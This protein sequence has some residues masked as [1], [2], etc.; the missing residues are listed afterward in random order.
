MRKYEQSP[1]VVVLYPGKTTS[2]LCSVLSIM[3]SLPSM[4]SIVFS[5]PHPPSCAFRAAGEGLLGLG[6]SW[7][8][9]RAWCRP[10]GPRRVTDSCQWW[11]MVVHPW[12]VCFQKQHGDRVQ[13]RG[14]CGECHQ[15][16]WWRVPCICSKGMRWKVAVHAAP[17]PMG[18]FTVHAS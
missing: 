14:R 12:S 3:M 2:Q 5:P 13:N 7:K 15:G 4:R 16:P 17:F 6:A 1:S 8:Y 10:C 9:V 18:F 11:C